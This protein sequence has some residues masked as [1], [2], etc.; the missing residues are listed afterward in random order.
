MDLSQFDEFAPPRDQQFVGMAYVMQLLQIM[1]AQL[2][3]LM[4]E[5]N[6]KF[7]QTVDGVGLF[8]IADAERL[9]AKC[10]DV[11]A[12]ISGKLNAAKSN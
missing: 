2:K 4:E 3:T 6:V 12:E 5:T 1:P 8:L 9:A 10:R 7:A 11:R